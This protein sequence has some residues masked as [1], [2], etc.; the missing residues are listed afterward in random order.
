[1][2]KQPTI[3][4]IDDDIDDQEIFLY[5]MKKI[6]PEATYVFARDGMDG[7]EK[8]NEGSFKAD[9][10]FLDVNMPRMDGLECLTELRKINSLEHVPIYIYSTS[11]ELDMPEKCKTLGCTGFIKK[12][13]NTDDVKKEFE[14]II[15]N[16]SLAE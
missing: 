5:V 12:H 3:F 15:A 8:I 13:I 6:V 2:P 10:I 16:I 7:L 1:M 4:L 14:K 11:G 9:V